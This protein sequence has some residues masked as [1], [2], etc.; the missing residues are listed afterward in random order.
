MPQ[1]KENDAP[2]EDVKELA[3]GWLTGQSFNN[4]LLAC[5]LIGGSYGLYYGLTV[6]IPG[7]L[8]QI[9]EGYERIQASDKEERRELREQYDSWI[10][11]MMDRRALSS[12]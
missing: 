8:K 9:Q 10:S 2:K 1:S 4:V 3:V 6:A 5:I 11:R 7:H 12:K